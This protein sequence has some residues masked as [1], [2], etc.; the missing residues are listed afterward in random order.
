MMGKKS[1]LLVNLHCF[2][3]YLKYLRNFEKRSKLTK[4]C[5]KIGVHLLNG[6][7]MQLLTL[8]PCLPSTCI[9]TEF[10]YLQ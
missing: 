9:Q 5:D 1:E 7:L 4:N 8:C 2:S 3:N 10:R 6:E